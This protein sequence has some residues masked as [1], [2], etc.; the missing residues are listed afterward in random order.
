MFAPLH[1]CAALLS[2][3]MGRG[4]YVGLQDIGVQPIVTDIARIED[5][6]M[7]YLNGTIIDHT[8]KLH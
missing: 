7:A 5:A 2:R 3:G 4:A 1:G 6:V 8:E